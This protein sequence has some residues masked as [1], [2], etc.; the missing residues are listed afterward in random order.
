M[1]AKDGY[2]GQAAINT[3]MGEVVFPASENEPHDAEQYQFEKVIGKRFKSGRAP[4]KRL[5]PR[6]KNII[7]LHLRCLSNRDIA[8]VTGLSEVSVAGTL[9]DTLSQEIILSYLEGI[10]EELKSLAP[11]AVDALRSGL[12]AGSIDTRL[13]A[14]DKFFHVTGRY[15]K[16]E[17][18]GE[19]AEDVLARA[20]ARV[21]VEQSG[22]LREL[23]RGAPRQIIDGRALPIKEENKADV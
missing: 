18:T 21:A 23:Q 7:A 16:A 22:Q 6:H 13:K 20:L 9:R 17:S 14:A 11:M 2:K 8:L 15:A 1:P 10:D 12:G 4:L 5:T 19:T 3:A